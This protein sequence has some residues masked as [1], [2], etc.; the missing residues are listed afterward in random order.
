[1]FL[2]QLL[3]LLAVPPSFKDSL[4]C[5]LLNDQVIVYVLLMFF[6][7]FLIIWQVSE[8]YF[9]ILANLLAFTFFSEIVLATAP[10]HFFWNHNT[11]HVFV[12]VHH[13]LRTAGQFIS[14]FILILSEISDIKDNQRAS[15]LEN[16][17]KEQEKH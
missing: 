8:S 6:D 5:N 9:F 14:H 1:M 7:K 2:L 12:V 4:M 11:S 10:L 15:Q 16:Y 17:W 13:S 3:S